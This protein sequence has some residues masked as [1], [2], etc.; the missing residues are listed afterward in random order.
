MCVIGVCVCVCA[1]LESRE[2]QSAMTTA[3]VRMAAKDMEKEVSKS[4]L[5]WHFILEAIL[6]VVVVT[7]ERRGTPEDQRT[8]RVTAATVPKQHRS[9]LR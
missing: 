2:H 1:G 4:L 8:R 7:T 6:C 5:Y 9:G 3:D